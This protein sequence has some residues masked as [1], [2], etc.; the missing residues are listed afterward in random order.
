MRAFQIVKGIPL[1]PDTRTKGQD[2]QQR[3]GDAGVAYLLAYAASRMDGVV[4][5]YASTGVGRHSAGRFADYLE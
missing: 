1:L 5:E 3:H 2:G 4:I